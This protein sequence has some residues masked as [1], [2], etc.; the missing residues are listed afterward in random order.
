MIHSAE[1]FFA[2]PTS[3]VPEEYRRAAHEEASPG[4]WHDVMERYPQL[5]SWV[6]HNKTVPLTVLVLLASDQDP[7]VRSAVADKRK[8]TIELFRQFACDPDD[9]VRARIA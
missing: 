7:D 6:A 5:R 4:V 3:S 9:G 2:L 8:L 1:E